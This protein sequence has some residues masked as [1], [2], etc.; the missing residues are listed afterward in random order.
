MNF[1]IT[2]GQ[3]RVD[4]HHS[5]FHY[6][7]LFPRHCHS[8]LQILAISLKKNVNDVF[9]VMCKGCYQVVPP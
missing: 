9:G 1:S 3:P 4:E 8:P 7:R 2:S 6:I 5:L